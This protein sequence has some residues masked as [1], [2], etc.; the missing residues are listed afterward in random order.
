MC[1]CHCPLYHVG[2]DESIFK[3][4]LYS[5]TQWIIK[6]VRGVRKKSEGPGEMV[7]AMQDEIRG[8]GF[9]MTT[10]VRPRRTRLRHL[11]LTAPACASL[12]SPHPL[13]PHCT[14]HTRLCPLVS[15]A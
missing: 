15:G 11:V 8:F 5:T 13:A 10:A 9:P 1:K 6:G 2:Q 7:S 12:P 4:F 14:C 3:A